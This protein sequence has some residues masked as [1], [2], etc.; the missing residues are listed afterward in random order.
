[1]EEQIHVYIHHVHCTT[2]HIVECDA[3]LIVARRIQNT[4][5]PFIDESVTFL[6]GIPLHLEGLLSLTSSLDSSDSSSSQ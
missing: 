3:D 6:I 4:F 5:V 2:R 1:M